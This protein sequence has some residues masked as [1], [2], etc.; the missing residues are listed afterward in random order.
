MN[1]HFK[2]STLFKSFAIFC[3]ARNIVG[4]VTPHGLRGRPLIIWGGV[5]QKEK[6]KFVRRVAEKKIPSKGPPKK[7]KLRLV[8]S[9]RELPLTTAGGD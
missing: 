8:F 5:V 2:V 6:K 4:V 7:K 1:K 9:L 3:F